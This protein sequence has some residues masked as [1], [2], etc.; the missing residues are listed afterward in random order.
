M[1]LSLVTFFGCASASVVGTAA[2]S[3][4]ESGQG[5]L[6]HRRGEPSIRL[7][8]SSEADIDEWWEERPTGVEQWFSV[9]APGANTV[10]I[11]VTVI[12]AD[13]VVNRHS[14]TL[15]NAGAALYYRDP[16]AWDARGTALPCWLEAAA[17][18]IRIVVQTAGA[19]GDVTVD[20]LLTPVWTAESDQTSAM[21][22][23]SASAA[24]D[25]DADGYDDVIVGAITWDGGQVN[26]GAAF[27]YR[28]GPLG[29]DAAP[30]WSVQSDQAFAQVGYSVAGAGDVNGDGFDDVLVGADEYDNPD[31]R[32]GR[33][34]LY[35]G[36]AAGP[37][38]LPAWTAE[39]DQVDAYFGISVASAGDVNGDDYGDVIVGSSFYTNGETG[40]GRAFVYHGSAAGLDPSAAW[41]AESDQVWASFGY[42]VASAGDVNADGY[43]DVLVGAVRYEATRSDEGGAW[44]YLGSALGLAA[45]PAWTAVGGEVGAAFGYSVA[46]LGD[47]NGDGYG[48]VAIGAPS[49]TNGQSFEGRALVYHGSAAGLE[50]LPAWAVESDQGDASTGFHVAGPGDLDADGYADLLVSSVLHDQGQPDEGVVFAYY[51]SA[52]GLAV[53]PGWTIEG[54]QNGANLGS[55]LEGAGDVNG[56]GLVDV[57]VGARGFDNGQV[58]EGRAFVFL[59]SCGNDADLDGFS[60][61]D[62][63]C[64]E[65]D[66]GVHPGAPELAD[67]VDQDCDGLVDEG[68]DWFDD[69]G[70]GVT[71]VGGDCDD[72]DSSRGLGALE[73]C[74]GIDQD[75]EGGIDE[76][77]ECS[78]DDGDGF[79]EQAGDCADGD[80]LVNAGAAEIPD[81]G[82]DD[83]CDG[84][85]DR[86]DPDGDGVDT[87]DCAPEDPTVFPGN[88]ESVNGIDD[89]CDG[90][91]DEGTAGGDD[92]GDGFSE[93]EGDPDDA[94]PAVFPEAL[95]TG[96]GNDDEAPRPTD[97]DADGFTRA[98]G[99]CDDENGWMNPGQVEICDDWDNDCD[100]VV[101]DACAHAIPENQDDPDGCG[102]GT[103]PVGSGWLVALALVVTRGARRRG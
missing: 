79:S 55:A 60:P 99:D 5:A 93:L 3:V 82:I 58:D 71:E 77:T 11:D 101:D 95:D 102:C 18:G 64:W 63:D 9:A 28:G 76:G 37:E 1:M 29:L 25:V 8:S 85:V 45:A 94:D 75:C 97:A 2:L 15:S 88:T 19:V 20:P 56:D 10:A 43:D 91:V 34:T 17:D 46:G 47:V 26:E 40:E 83:D 80:P 50:A 103:G 78:D 31:S 100:G 61:C 7:V 30:A 98:Q 67:G 62:G 4:S 44:L 27:L 32:E 48:D 38:A 39:G 72:G 84:T 23:W 22:A 87:G 16:A 53:V 96:G 65:G 36:S 52:A 57:L 70:D 59:G 42:D 6:I 14:A 81:N 90:L 92:D 69:D 41:T 54:D 89:D 49:Y 86:P 51:G 13:V 12:G 35:L 68:T 33:A 21:F 24:G 66:A 73:V 74:D